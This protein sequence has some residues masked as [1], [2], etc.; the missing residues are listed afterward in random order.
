MLAL[1]AFF[2]VYSFLSLGTAFLLAINVDSIDDHLPDAYEGKPS[3]KAKKVS[4]IVPCRNEAEDIRGCIDSIL[5]QDYPELEVIVAD[6]NS[7][8]GTWEIL[9]SYGNRI[10]AIR[11]GERQPGWTGKNWGAHLGYRVAEGELLLFV[12]GDMVLAPEVVSKSVASMTH[13]SADLFSLGPK[14]EM[15]G[16]WEKLML[17]LFAQFI[18]LLCMPPLMNRDRG[19]MVMA[20]GQYMMMKRSAYEKC[21]THEAIKGRVVEDINLAKLFRKNGFRIRFYWASKYLS[22]RMYRNA[23]ELW[24]G[25]VRDIQGEVGKRYIIHTANILY[26]AL[27]FYLPFWMLYFSAAQGSVI[28][29]AFAAASIIFIVLRMVIFQVGTESP[30]YLALLYPLSIG[31]YLLI[32]VSAFLRAVAGYGVLWKDRNYSMTSE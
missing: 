19:H 2:A 30:V 25:V 6:G 11:E 10:N 1:F 17:P 14:M 20:N 22:T 29:F 3:A 28:L 7:E 5:A 26:L 12:D 18:L 4:I 23:G 32:A 8:D 27:T 16:F 9:Q 31:V 15:K 24:E 21:G 13:E